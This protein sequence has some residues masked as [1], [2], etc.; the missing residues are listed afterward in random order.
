MTQ[1]GDSN[2]P[3]AD[4]S[5]RYFTCMSSAWIEPASLTFTAVGSVATAIAVYIGVAALADARRALKL[6]QES[7][8]TE[9]IARVGDIIDET[10][11]F[12]KQIEA[13]LLEVVAV[14]YPWDEPNTGLLDAAD[15]ARSRTD[16]CMLR[17]KAQ[18]HVIRG[19]FA[20]IAS[21][22]TDGDADRAS[23]P[24]TSGRD[25]VLVAFDWFESAVWTM[26]HGLYNTRIPTQPDGRPLPSAEWYV[27]EALRQTAGT[28]SNVE[29]L[30]SMTP[31]RISNARRDSIERPTSVEGGDPDQKQFV[32][33]RGEVVAD[34][35]ESV[36]HGGTAA[37]DIWEAIPDVE[38]LR[39]YNLADVRKEI[40][41]QSGYHFAYLNSTRH[42]ADHAGENLFT[43]FERF[44]SVYGGHIRES[45]RR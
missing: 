15:V 2:L 7:N 29:E 41:V 33:A 25:E 31:D 39:S 12:G 32:A 44:A 14:P 18:R 24:V 28:F 10:I 8:I 45:G 3:E 38:R 4:C 30:P 1:R 43:A 9:R 20:S 6:T 22:A 23:D 37:A 35:A 40:E 11:R 34:V 17:L 27:V 21:G 42:F 5:I 16:A 13:N 36:G 26:Y 19:R